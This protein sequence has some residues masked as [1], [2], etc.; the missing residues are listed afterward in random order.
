[1]R[2]MSL[3]RILTWAVMLGA[4][5]FSGPNVPAQALAALREGLSLLA[6]RLGMGR[7]YKS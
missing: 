1:M 3:L 2:A 6:R 7:A 4:T 5:A